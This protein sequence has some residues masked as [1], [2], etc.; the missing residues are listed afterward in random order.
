[1]SGYGFA[2]NIMLKGLSAAWRYY[3]KPRSIKF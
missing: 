2:F 3:E 1:M